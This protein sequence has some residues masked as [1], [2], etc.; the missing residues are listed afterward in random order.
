VFY[1]EVDLTGIS[2]RR[3]WESWEDFA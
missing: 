3:I 2:G 1:R